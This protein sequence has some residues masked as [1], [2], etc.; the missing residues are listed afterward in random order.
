MLTLNED[1]DE[2]G[3]LIQQIG[4]FTQ[5][6]FNNQGLPTWGLPYLAATTESPRAGAIEVWQIFNLTGDTHPI[7]FHLVNVQVIQRQRFSG[8][9]RQI[10]VQRSRNSA[11]CQRSGLEGNGAHESR[12]SYD[13]YHA[14]QSSKITCIHG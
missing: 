2:Y 12:R 5:N 8:V 6:G 4:T 7:H 3:R 10:P 11:R 9:P 14:V 1:F 13:G